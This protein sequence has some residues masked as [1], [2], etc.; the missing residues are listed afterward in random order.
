MKQASILIVD[1]NKSVLSAL[2][3]LLGGRCK[4]VR[5]LSSPNMLLN[6]LRQGNYDLLL[7]DM[8]FSA[9]INSG[10]EG[11]YW[12]QRVLNETPGVDVLMI[13]AYGDVELAVK[14]VRMGAVDFVLKPWNN[15][16]LLTSIEATLRLAASRKEVKKLKGSN[17]A[18]DTAVSGLPVRTDFASPAWKK[19]ADMVQKVAVTNANVLITGE[20]GTGKEVVAREIHRLSTRAASTLVSVDMGAVADTL[21]ESEL[22]GHKKGA[23]TDAAAD[24]VG[25]IEEAHN[26]TLFLDEIGNLPL[27]LQAKLLTVLQNRTVTRV[28]ENKPV[29]VDVRLICA[30]NCDL[31][32]MVGT[33]RFREDLLYRINT[34]HIEL[35]PLRDRKED[36]AT[37]ADFFL[38]KYKAQYQR[39]QLTLSDAA[40]H[41]LE[42][43]VWPGNVRELQHAIE[44]AV[45]L[46][47][48][49]VVKPSDFIFRETTSGA[50]SVA[51][52]TLEDM[53]RK[54]IADAIAR[55]DGNLSGVA[56]QLGISRQTLYNKIKKYGL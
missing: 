21:F 26:G 37:L 19:V 47:E 52:G 11:L 2:E 22:F 5:T 34:I 55:F 36:V 25:K 27:P 31:P 33:G 39:P 8:N 13:T 35:P 54:L 18:A 32:Q 24:R 10:N 4:K 42:G 16:K 56:A 50:A 6:E 40:L 44:K 17:A 9:G 53:E 14:A 30:T 41:K 3:L 43:Y 29:N 28:G 12:L 51:D 48:G 20:N 23:F 15:D 49:N 45:I 38:S 1:D 46:G 7:L